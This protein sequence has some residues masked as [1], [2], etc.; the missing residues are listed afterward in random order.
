M[1]WFGYLPLCL[2]SEERW[3][4][5]DPVTLSCPLFFPSQHL[6]DEARMHGSAAG[7][8]DWLHFEL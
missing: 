1:W 8:E 6:L 4:V 5:F 3:A 2:L 7:T